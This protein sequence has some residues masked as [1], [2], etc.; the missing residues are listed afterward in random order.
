MFPGGALRLTPLEDSSEPKKPL[1]RVQERD[2]KRLIWGNSDL[3][4]SQ[5]Y[6]EAFGHA[7]ASVWS[8]HRVELLDEAAVN[9]QTFASEINVVVA[10][11]LFGPLPQHAQWLDAELH[12]V[13]RAL[14]N[15]K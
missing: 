13:F 5:A 2:G 11:D 3:K 8:D 6:P 15:S 1:V 10:N 14:Q 4:G 9:L 7:V 12:D